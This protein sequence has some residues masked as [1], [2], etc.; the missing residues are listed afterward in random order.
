MTTSTEQEH[1]IYIYFIFI[2]NCIV[3]IKYYKY[4]VIQHFYPTL[5]WNSHLVWELDTKVGAKLNCILIGS[6][7]LVFY[8]N[9]SIDFLRQ[10]IS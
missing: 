9:Q 3:Q 4:N 2:W 5:Q 1:N 6:I 10:L 7:L 8:N